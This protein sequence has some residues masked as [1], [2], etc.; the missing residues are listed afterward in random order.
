MI[1]ELHSQGPVVQ[2]IMSLTS[3]LLGQ[4]NKCFTTL[5]KKNDFI[6]KYNDIFVEKN[7]RSF[8]T[9]TRQLTM[10]LLLNN[11][12]QTSF[13]ILVWVYVQFA[14]ALRL[15]CVFGMDVA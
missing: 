9:T 13:P 15:T 10:S 11:Q 8:C 5:L 6:T 4:P 3:S 1:R 14:R 7:E 2:S 12:A